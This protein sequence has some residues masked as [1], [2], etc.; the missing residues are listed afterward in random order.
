MLS[1][2]N[3]RD[4]FQHTVFHLISL[5]VCSRKAERL[6]LQNVATA[7]DRFGFSTSVFTCLFLLILCAN[8]S[9]HIRFQSFCRQSRPLQL[10][11]AQC[12]CWASSLFCLLCTHTPHGSIPCR[13]QVNHGGNQ[14]GATSCSHKG[15]P[16]IYMVAFECIFL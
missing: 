10:H 3:H 14:L 15:F 1:H 13:D 11:M 9:D 5:V 2:K 6:I 7:L 16:T 4:P 8:H 12:M